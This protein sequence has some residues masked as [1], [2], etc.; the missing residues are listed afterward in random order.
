MN[1]VFKLPNGGALYLHNEIK[2]VCDVIR[3]AQKDYNLACE[4]ATTHA[5]HKWSILPWY[6]KIH[7]KVCTGIF[8]GLILP[9]ITPDIYWVW[10]RDKY[11][12]ALAE[13]KHSGIISSGLV[14]KYYNNNYNAGQELIKL[15]GSKRNCYLNPDQI[16]V[17][18][19][20]KKFISKKEEEQTN[21]N[22]S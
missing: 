16:S 7:Y 17:M 12:E 14:S 5:E 22:N 8:F 18:S 4:M 13:Y 10:Y 6:M 11:E 2:Q 20:V 3:K 1:S 19:L 9:V 21:E 15:K